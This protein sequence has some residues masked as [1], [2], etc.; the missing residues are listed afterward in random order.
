VEAI[1]VAI[2]ASIGGILAALIQKGRKENKD[3]HNH[4]VSMI[5]VLHKDV[6]KVDQKISNHIDWHLDN[7]D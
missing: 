3:D 7:K 2:I 5:K 1:V 4:V 6:S